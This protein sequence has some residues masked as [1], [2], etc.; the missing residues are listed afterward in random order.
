MFLAQDTS[1]DPNREPNLEP[2]PD[3]PDTGIATLSHPP[4]QPHKRK[5]CLGVS[6]C[7]GV[8]GGKD[9]GACEGGRALAD[10]EHKGAQDYWKILLYPTLRN[11]CVTQLNFPENA[12]MPFH[13]H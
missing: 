6:V 2:D 12:N 11:E 4:P 1:A 8:N 10:R 5:G 9:Q 3:F 13:P 7:M